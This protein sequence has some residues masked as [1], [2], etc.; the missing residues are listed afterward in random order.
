MSGLPSN[1][2]P[3]F[4]KRNPH[5]AHLYGTGAAATRLEAQQPVSDAPVFR[6]GDRA[7]VKLNKLE[8]AYY[9]Y[10]KDRILSARI[11]AAHYGEK[12]PS[13]WIGVQSI[14]LKLGHMCRYTPDFWTI[15]EDGV[16]EAR[17]VKG[18]MFW[19]DAKVKLKVAASTYPFIRFF[20]VTRDNIW[21]DH[22]IIPSGVTEA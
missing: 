9:Q 6:K 3:S 10:L 14:T 1:P 5:L 21:W 16:L 22:K 12:A 7:S 8:T 2:L 13:D 4:V 20:L 19:E 15:D 17:E 11:A 18:K